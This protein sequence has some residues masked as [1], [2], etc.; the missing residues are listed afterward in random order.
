MSVRVTCVS[1]DR[2]AGGWVGRH[3]GFE[4]RARQTCTDSEADSSILLLGR[5]EFHFCQTTARLIP[6][7]RGREDSVIT[8]IVLMAAIL[9]I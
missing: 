4:V 7:K 3:G 9:I 1:G 2:G 8:Q 6:L 5:G